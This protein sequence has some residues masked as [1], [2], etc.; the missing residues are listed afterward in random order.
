M[1]V[2]AG[3][4]G[5]G[6][7][8]P[9]ANTDSDAATTDGGTEGLDTDLESGSFTDVETTALDSTGMLPDAVCEAGEQGCSSQGYLQV[10]GEAGQVWFEGPCPA[11]SACVPCEDGDFCVE[12]GCVPA[13]GG[14]EAHAGSGCE[15]IVQAALNPSFATDG[16]TVA[17][18]SADTSAE[19]QLLRV[20]LGTADETV[21]EEVS[22]APLESV[23]WSLGADTGT[24]VSSLTTG[25]MMRVRSDRAVVAYQQGPELLTTGNDSSLLLPD[26]VLGWTYVIPSFRPTTTRFDLSSPP[27]FFDV[28]ALS[29]GTTVEWTPTSATEG[30]GPFEAVPAG[31]TGSIALNR[32]DALRVTG[33][34]ASRGFGGDDLSGTVV[35]AS[36]RIRVASGIRCATVPLPEPPA[37]G[38]CDPLQEV[39]I[40]VERWDAE[41]VVPPPPPRDNENHYWRVYAG[42]DDTTFTTEPQVLSVDNCPPPAVFDGGACTLPQLGSWIEIEVENGTAFVVRGVTG[43]D[44]SMVVGYLQSRELAGVRP[45]TATD[46][47]D[48][49][50][51]QLPGVYAFGTEAIATSWQ[52]FQQ[53]YVQVV[54]P[55]GGATVFIGG[56][57]VNG[58]TVVGDYEYVHVPFTGTALVESSEPIGVTQYGYNASDEINPDCINDAAPGQC[59]SSYA[60]GLGWNFAD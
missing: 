29:D 45:E 53:Q 50:M 16:V 54:R 41:T 40:P 37:S 22:L 5:P 57:G 3:A 60:H 47:G 6:P 31:G 18:P 43:A 46:V 39:L 2:A 44:R 24:T 20:G 55:A 10:C 8:L 59:A 30:A 51:V 56:N 48:P 35:S 38:Y 58:W 28:V 33:V 32:Y 12:A 17:N 9:Q 11:G 14:L 52:G 7:L 13:C 26:H 49:A 27:S 4:C 42:G 25:G 21:V 34:A 15:F 23:V 1:V 36:A 19:V